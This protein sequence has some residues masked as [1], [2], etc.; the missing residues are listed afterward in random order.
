MKKLKLF[1]L[2]LLY[3]LIFVAIFPLV[4]YE[5]YRIYNLNHHNIDS[6]WS[7]FRSTYSLFFLIMCG[8][9]LLLY[10]KWHI[11]AGVISICLGIYYF[12]QVIESF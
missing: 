3:L 9:V 1:Y 4:Q 2:I 5:Y 8:A 6:F 11:L 7:E 12:I 10:G